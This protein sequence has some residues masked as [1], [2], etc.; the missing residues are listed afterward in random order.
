MTKYAAVT[1][2][3]SFMLLLKL[4]DDVRYIIRSCHELSHF[5]VNVLKEHFLSPVC[6]TS[7]QNIRCMF[8]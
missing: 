6:H 1:L 2:L 7:S 3:I 8:C 4:V 5:F